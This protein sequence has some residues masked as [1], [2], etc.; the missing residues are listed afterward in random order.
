MQDKT[1]DQQCFLCKRPAVTMYESTP[2]CRKHA[3]ELA[4]DLEKLQ[5][6]ATEDYYENK[7]TLAKLE[8]DRRSSD[9][10]FEADRKRLNMTFL[11][12]GG[13][14]LLLMIIGTIRG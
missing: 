7:R 9:N 1:N 5:N 12:F 8:Q 4:D 14:I 10:Q 2:Y 11:I 3:N 6:R 13:L